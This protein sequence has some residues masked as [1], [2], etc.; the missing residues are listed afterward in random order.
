[1]TRQ[2]SGSQGG[3]AAARGTD[4]WVSRPG[5]AESGREVPNSPQRRPPQRRLARERGP[6]RRERGARGAGGGGRRVRGLPRRPQCHPPGRRAPGVSSPSDAPRRP[7]IRLPGA[8]ISPRPRGGES[9]AKPGGPPG[10]LRG[11]DAGTRPG[12]ER[13]RAARALTRVGQRAEPARGDA[14]A[15][16][17]RRAERAGGAA[18]AAVRPAR[19]TRRPEDGCRRPGTAPATAAPEPAASPASG[20]RPALMYVGWAPAPG[21]EGACGVSAPSAPGCAQ[22]T[23]PPSHCSGGHPPDPDS[24]F[25]NVGGWFAPV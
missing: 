5:R 17:T 7:G 13:R 11:G 8:E 18:L 16:C 25:V 24:E 1:M 23:V 22:G 19:V 12:A 20:P 2:E 6:Q 10:A 21:A 14:L 3:Q 4:R 15:G 9:E